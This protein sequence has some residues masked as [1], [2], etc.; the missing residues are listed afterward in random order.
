MFRLN[1]KLCTFTNT[2]TTYT[3]WV[4]AYAI[5]GC[6]NRIVYFNTTY[7]K[8]VHT[9]FQFVKHRYQMRQDNH[10]ATYISQWL[11]LHPIIYCIKMNNKNEFQFISSCTLRKSLGTISKYQKSTEIYKTLPHWV[12]FPCK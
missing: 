6:T 5:L 7:T 8:N 2:T 12:K 4:Y 9:N 1:W 10:W 11:I 3:N